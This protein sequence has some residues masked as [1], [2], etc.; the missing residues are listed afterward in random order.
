MADDH[1]KNRP[2]SRATWDPPL[3]ALES[4]SRRFPAETFVLDYYEPGNGF[5][6]SAT[7]RNGGCI[8]SHAKT[9]EVV[10]RIGTEVFGWGT[11]EEQP[12]I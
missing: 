9:P 2:G 11:T 8:Q 4:L 7:F 6:S 10:R 3:A 1:G 5:A 12:P